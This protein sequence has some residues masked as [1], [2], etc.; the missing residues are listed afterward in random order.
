MLNRLEA[1][2][3][4]IRTVRPPLE[5]FY[6]SLSDEQKARFNAVGPDIGREPPRTTRSD[7]Q[8]RNGCADPKPGLTNLPI[9]R[10]EETVRPNDR[11]QPALDK[12][13]EATGKAVSILQAACPDNVP[14]TPPGRLAAMDQRTDAM[15]QAA[16]T[17]KPALDEFYATLSSEQKARFNTLGRREVRG[18]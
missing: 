6:N 10:I 1:T 16:Q 11:Q 9:E 7:D 12:L 18:G 4:A 17:V 5:A 13:S 2:L 14:Q 3:I 8:P 15:L